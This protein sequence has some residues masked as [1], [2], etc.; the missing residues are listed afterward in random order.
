MNRFTHPSL[1]VLIVVFI[2]SACSLSGGPGGSGR[3]DPSGGSAGGGSSGSDD[4]SDGI[5]HPGGDDLVFSMGYEG[6]FVPVEMAVAQVPTFVLLGD[7]RVITQGA[8][9][10][11]FPGPLL[12]ALQVRQLT[13]DG[14]Q[15]VL[16]GVISTGLFDADADLRGAANMVADASDTVFTLNAGDR[17]VTVK[18]YGLGTLMPDMPTQGIAP[19]EVEAH[20]TLQR[21]SEQLLTIDQVL[22]ADAFTDTGWQPYEPDAYRLYIRDAT[23]DP[24]GEL[25]GQVREWPTDDDPATIGEEVAVFGGST[26][27]VV[28]DG[29]AWGEEL[30]AANQNTRWTMDGETL[31]A[32]I[33]RPLFPHE[34]Q[35]CSEVAPGA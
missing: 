34:A 35:V 5:A 6:G 19:A 17:Q 23:S 33:A 22:P 31:Y 9:T 2:V 18:V 27:C 13:E 30:M 25:Q 4:P 15:Q 11:E 8:M 24:E 29:A 32:I 10:L 14:V 21:L 3:S 20:Q 28:V 26:R 12:P 1:L 7:G 16:D